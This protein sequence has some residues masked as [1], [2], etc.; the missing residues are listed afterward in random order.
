MFQ[1]LWRLGL[2][3]FLSNASG[4]INTSWYSPS[5]TLLM[6]E[7]LPMLP[8]QTA[9]HDPSSCICSLGLSS[10]TEIPM[11]IHKLQWKIEVFSFEDGR[12]QMAAR[13]ST[14]FS[15]IPLPKYHETV[16]ASNKVVNGFFLF[17][18]QC[19]HS[20]LIHPMI[21]NCTALQKSSI[22]VYPK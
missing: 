16:L 20:K 15:R 10:E 14:T 2:K 8:Q 1:W 19:L 5:N 6:T 7:S 4:L 17:V 11:A 9:L 3:L 12:T 22:V 21:A 18:L 13:H